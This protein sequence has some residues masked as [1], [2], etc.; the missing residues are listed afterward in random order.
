MKTCYICDAPLPRKRSKLCS[1]LCSKIANC[2][3][4]ERKKFGKPVTFGAFSR[5]VYCQICKKFAYAPRYDCIAYCG[6]C[7][8]N[9]SFTAEALAKKTHRAPTA[10]FKSLNQFREKRFAILKRDNFKCV[11]CGRSSIEH[12]VTLHVDHIIPVAKGGKDIASN[13]ITACDT[14]NRQKSASRLKSSNERRIL[15]VVE[16][17]NLDKGIDPDKVYIAPRS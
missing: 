17:R 5:V 7:K 15:A 8:P 4:I 2:Q 16:R 13:L 12:G 1:D 14:C 11:Y 9:G 10:V 3:R 6:K